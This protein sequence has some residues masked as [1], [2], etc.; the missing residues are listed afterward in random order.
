MPLPFPCLAGSLSLDA[1]NKGNEKLSDLVG[2]ASRIMV[3]TGAGVSTGSGISDFRGPK[4]VWKR[5]K[6]VMYREFMRSEEARVEYWDQ[7]LEAY[8][9]FKAA[10]PNKTHFAIVELERAGKLEML[11]TQNIDGLHERAGNS[12]ER[13]VE[14]H[15]T[16][17]RVE[18]Q[19]CGEE[20]DLEGSFAYF[21][22]HRESPSCA[23]GGHLKPAT[24]SF[25]QSLNEEDLERAGGAAKG[26]DLVIALGSTLS[27]FP[28]A[29]FPLAAARRGVPYV[30]INRGETDHDELR[31]VSLRLEGDVANIF[32]PAVEQ[33]LGS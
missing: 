12:R 7:K 11:V 19:S 21:E 2:A 15:G 27:V 28:A 18:C 14:L 16:N 8:P 25:G 22:K 24:I 13:L 26:C 33:A 17:G 6:P 3:F 32:P 23:C 9:Q 1:M 5:R 20:A 4:G 29:E 10:R 31:W 30:V